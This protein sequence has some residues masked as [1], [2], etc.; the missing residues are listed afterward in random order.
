MCI[1]DSCQYDAR[2]FNG[3]TLYHVL[4]VHPFMIVKGQVMENPFHIRPKE[5]N[6]RQ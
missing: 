4:Q 5:F 6:R 2:L 1:R 3:G